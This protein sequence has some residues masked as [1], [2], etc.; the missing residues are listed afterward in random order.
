[1]RFVRSRADRQVGKPKGVA[2]KPVP[3]RKV[4]LRRKNRPRQERFRQE[5]ACFRVRLIFVVV[6]IR[7]DLD[8][9]A[10]IVIIIIQIGGILNDVIIVF[11]RIQID[12]DILATIIFRDAFDL[13]YRGFIDAFGT[14]HICRLV[15]TTFGADRR[16]A[17]QIVEFLHRRKRKR[18][19]DPVPVSPWLRLLILISGFGHATD[20]AS[21]AAMPAYAGS[22]KC[23]CPSVV[24]IFCTKS[25]L[26]KG[27]QALRRNA[28]IFPAV[29]R[30]WRLRQ[31]LRHLKLTSTASE[32]DEAG[33][34][35]RAENYCMSAQ[36]APLRV[37]RA[38]APLRGDVVVP[39]DKSISHRALMLAAMAEGWSE[40][41]G[42]L[43]G[44]D[45]L[46][47]ASAM[48][49]L[50]A[51]IRQDGARGSFKAM[52]HKVCGSLTMCSIWA[53]PARRPFDGGD[54]LNAAL[55]TVS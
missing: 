17:Y 21:N 43:E 24:R 23:V 18:V 13:I 4:L 32:R 40:I 44:E 53:I 9:R 35:E 54:S 50:G 36:V 10:E 37:Q 14:R 48:R 8:F 29:C 38:P 22:V 26:I 27:G 2:L 33:M 7:V 39:G 6:R 1:M 5:P 42:L 19:S 30:R 20:A 46:R 49:A 41:S 16:T 55:L 31:V 47:T 11:I 3:K 51:E 52:A 45:V 12:V 28:G 15:H 34:S 25:R